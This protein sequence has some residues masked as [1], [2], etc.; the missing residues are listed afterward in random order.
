M[1]TSTETS[2]GDAPPGEVPSAGEVE[3]EPGEVDGDDESVG[4]DEAESVGDDDGEPDGN[5]DAGDVFVV[6]EGVGCGFDDFFGFG[7]F[8]TVIGLLPPGWP[9]NSDVIECE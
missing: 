9:G 8:D 6:E 1:A 2:E 4:D 7:V 3:L 5:G